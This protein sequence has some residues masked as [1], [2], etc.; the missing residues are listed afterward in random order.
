M[1][2]FR[3]L[4]HA[5]DMIGEPVVSHEHRVGEGLRPFEPEETRAPGEFAG[6]GVAPLP[7]VDR[8]TD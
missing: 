2:P 8:P 5:G 4:L 6:G 7:A 3:Q 1:V